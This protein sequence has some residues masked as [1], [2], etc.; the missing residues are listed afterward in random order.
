MQ[1]P[2]PMSMQPVHGVQAPFTHVFVD[3]H[4]LHTAPFVPQ[5]AGVG[6]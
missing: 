6:V 3:W 2:V 5:R 4:A 1:L